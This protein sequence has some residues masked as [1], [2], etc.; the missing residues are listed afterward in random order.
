MFH[1]FS[2]E[3]RCPNITESVNAKLISGNP[4]FAPDTVL[5]YECN[6]GYE[7]ID[8]QQELS[9]KKD[10]QWSGKAPNCTGS[11]HISCHLNIKT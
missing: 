10:G 4:P 3:R 2:L 7:L 5:L 6:E 11:V 9:C 1:N 8:G